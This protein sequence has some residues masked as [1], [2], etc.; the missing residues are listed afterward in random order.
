MNHTSLKY[1]YAKNDFY[2]KVLSFGKKISLIHN[3]NKQEHTKFQDENIK[4][5]IYSFISKIGN[6]L[7]LRIIGKK[8]IFR[9]RLESIF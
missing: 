9:M 8:I 3:I 1:T 7:K 4:L 6:I 2:E 5:I